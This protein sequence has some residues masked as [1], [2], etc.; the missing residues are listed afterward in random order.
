MRVYFY[1]LGCRVNQYETDAVRKL[2][3]C[4]G[5]TSVFSPET[6]DIIIVNTCSVTGEADRKSRQQLRHMRKVNTEAVICA[7]GCQVEA[8]TGRIEAD[9]IL[10]TRD[11]NL[12]VERIKE[13]IFSRENSTSPTPGFCMH[14][15]PEVSKTDVYHE[16]GTVLSPEGTR[17]FIKIEDGCNNFCSYC[18]IP[19]T[20]GRV[21]S[22]EKQNILEEAR[23]LAT[24]G[25]HEVVLTGI[26]LC[27]YGRDRGEG[28]EALLRLIGA[29]AEIDGIERIRLG[30]LEPMSL[31]PEFIEGLSHIDKLCPHFHL[32]L[33]SGS[34]TV[35]KRMNRKYLTSDYE[36]RVKLLREFFPHMS[37]TTDVICGF[38]GETETEFEE[39]CEFVRR[40]RINKLHVFPYSIREG[41]V[42]AK[43]GQVP[44]EIGKK[45]TKLLTEVSAEAER[46]FAAS[47]IGEEV[48]ILIES[49]S[50]EVPTGISEEKGVYYTGYT[51]EYV[52]ALVRFDSEECGRAWVGRIFTGKIKEIFTNCVV[53]DV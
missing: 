53:V 43:M 3:E 15:R 6:A 16:F 5:W 27:S 39:T 45:R 41:T 29:V 13:F 47:F 51:R 40:L 50:N 26:H 21:A 46:S 2:C 9:V 24:E 37:L 11:K 19:Y 48:A 10:G 23:T 49:I 30:S 17:A 22:R 38:P 35:L 4:E 12:A 28:P 33:Q 7:M 18:I 8:A 25:Y 52:R 34:D 14:V 42:A 20:R 31:T 36:A 1:T 32:S 44:H